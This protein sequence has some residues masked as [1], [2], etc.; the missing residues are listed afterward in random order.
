[1]VPTP[2][3]SLDLGQRGLER[4]VGSAAL[5]ELQ[6]QFSQFPDQI[7]AAFAVGFIPGHV[8]CPYL[9]KR[10]K[11]PRGDLAA[12]ARRR[13]AAFGSGGRRLVQTA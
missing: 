2:K 11:D 3:P 13:S 8:W 9:R 7:R 1:M 12:T 6:L 5:L 10:F 4:A